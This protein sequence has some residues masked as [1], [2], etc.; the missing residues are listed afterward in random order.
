MAMAA[1]QASLALAKTAVRSSRPVF[2]MLAVK[3]IDATA[4]AFHATVNGVQGLG[5]P[6][7]FE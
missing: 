5:T 1:W 4:H 2:M 3:A 7:F 6:E